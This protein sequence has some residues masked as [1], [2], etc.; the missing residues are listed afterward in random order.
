MGNVS[1]G[2]NSLAFL[3]LA[4]D[5]DRKTEDIKSKA[6]NLENRL[7]MLGGIRKIYPDGTQPGEWIPADTECVLNLPYGNSLIFG[8]YALFFLM[9]TT[10]D[11]GVFSLYGDLD[12]VNFTLNKTDG[13]VHYTTYDGLARAYAVHFG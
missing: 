1:A 2:G 11:I 13:K 7:D 9:R 6:E 8:N 10:N 5:L 12:R 3:R 4:G